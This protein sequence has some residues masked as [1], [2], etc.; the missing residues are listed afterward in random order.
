MEI[1]KKVKE[2]QP[3]TSQ[4][5]RLDQVRGAD[6]EPEIRKERMSLFSFSVKALIPIFPLLNMSLFYFS[7][8]GKPKAFHNLF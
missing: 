2:R 5:T 6:T 8:V 4:R 7:A 3:R 1:K